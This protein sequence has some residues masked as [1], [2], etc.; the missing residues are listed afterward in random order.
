SLDYGPDIGAAFK[1]ARE[2]R[3]LSLQDV[4]DRTRVRRQYLA[5]L[6]DMQLDQ[7]PSRPFAIGYVKSYASVLGFDED[8]AVARFKLSAPDSKGELRAPIGVGY[9]PERRFGVIGAAGAVLV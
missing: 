6:E 7:L 3:G 1:A 8:Q 4:S 9:E 5:A 2:A